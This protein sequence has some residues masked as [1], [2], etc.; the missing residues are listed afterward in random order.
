MKVKNYLISLILGAGFA[1]S[2]CSQWTV[3]GQNIV[4]KPD[5]STDM[6][7]TLTGIYSKGNEKSLPIVHSDAF[8]ISLKTMYL[9]YIQSTCN[10]DVLVYADVYEINEANKLR[11][12][13]FHVQDQAPTSY[14]NVKDVLLYGPNHFNDK[15]ITIKLY[16][17]DLAKRDNVL[18]SEFL[19]F[20]ANAA[21]T[22]QPEYGPAIQTASSVMQYFIANNPDA[23]EFFQ[24]ITFYP[25]SEAMEILN[26]GTRLPAPLKTGDYIVV[27]KED[28]DRCVLNRWW[29]F[30]PRAEETA[31]SEFDPANVFYSPSSGRLRHK[32]ETKIVDY[33]DKTYAVF[34]VSKATAAAADDVLKDISKNADTI[35]SEVATKGSDLEKTKSLQ[36]IGSSA[37]AALKFFLIKCIGISNR[38]CSGKARLATTLLK[39]AEGLM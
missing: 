8:Q 13:A 22:A 28:R 1:F 39:V 5:K 37:E 7:C 10:F 34:T 11:R 18:F 23:V 3:T 27:K 4:V 14:L 9:K 16:V 20:T 38:P 19:K 15:P 24:E 17:L 26:D 36:S 35:I 33:T 32:E 31:K 29:W 6:D 25:D 21:S 2:G 12:V 30:D